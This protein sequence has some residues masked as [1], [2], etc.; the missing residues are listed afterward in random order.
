MQ[1]TFAVPRLAP[2][3]LHASYTLWQFYKGAEGLF[4][5]RHGGKFNWDNI[6]FLRRAAFIKIS[7]AF[8]LFRVL[9]I[10]AVC[11]II[12]NIHILLDF[13]ITIYALLSFLL[14]SFVDIYVNDL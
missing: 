13:R 7:Q 5:T 4:W 8:F 1:G 14:L 9:L 12:C 6:I 10:I 2:I 11:Y 3:L